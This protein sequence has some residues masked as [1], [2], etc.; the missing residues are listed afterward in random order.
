MKALRT[1][2]THGRQSS[3]QSHYASRTIDAGKL[4]KLVYHTRAA[5]KRSERPLD[6]VLNLLENVKSYL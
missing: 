6:F 1:S 5:C 4:G 2:K 3:Q